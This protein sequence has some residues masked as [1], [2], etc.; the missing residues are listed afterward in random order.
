MFFSINEGMNSCIP[1]LIQTNTRFICHSESR[2][3]MW[4]VNERVKQVYIYVSLLN[5]SL[6]QY[7]TKDDRH[8]SI[9]INLCENN[10]VI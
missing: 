10:T 9:L 5:K 2:C 1:V 8:F 4:S 6:T 3:E 7:G